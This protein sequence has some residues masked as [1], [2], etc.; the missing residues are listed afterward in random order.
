[1]EMIDYDNYHQNVPIVA[2]QT[3][4]VGKDLVH[5]I[6]HQP[7]VKEQVQKALPSNIPVDRFLRAAMTE[8]R[9]N[10]KLL[11]CDPVSFAGCIIECAQLGLLPGSSLGYA[12]FVPFYSSKEKKYLCQ[13]II[14]YIG[15][16]ELAYRG[17]FVSGI[18]SR[19]V[20]EGDHFYQCDGNNERFEHESLHDES[21]PM[22]HV[23]AYAKLKS[24]GFV[25]EVIPLNQINSLMEK[26][27]GKDSWRDHTVAML[28]KTAV[29]RLCKY[30][31][32]DPLLEMAIQLD[33]PSMNDVQKTEYVVEQDKQEGVAERLKKKLR[34]E[35]NG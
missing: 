5:Y 32:K 4:T 8:V 22:T 28:R 12:Y 30:I 23:Y 24:G 21:R 19:V 35:K 29:R 20:R 25:S 13:I 6:M 2:V 18:T 11:Q 26:N 9:N 7:W 3:Q 10:P 33:D 15:L 17:G 14:G 31:P 34:G 27:K 1:M 16:I